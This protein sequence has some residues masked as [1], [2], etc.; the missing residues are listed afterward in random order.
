MYLAS[1]MAGLED[2]G[3]KAFTCSS[4]DIRGVPPEVPPGT[5]YPLDLEGH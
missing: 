1:M 2:A 4:S 5:F 3:E